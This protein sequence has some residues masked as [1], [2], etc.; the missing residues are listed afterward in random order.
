MN[1][2]WKDIDWLEAMFQISNTGRLRSIDRII[3]Y[4]DGRMYIYKSKEYFPSYNRG[5]CIQTLNL[6]GKAIPVKFHR[7]VAEAFIPN[8]NNLPEVNHIDGDKTNNNVSNLEWCTSSENKKHAYKLGLKLPT[9]GSKCGMSKLTENQVL[10]I[11][12]LKNKYIYKEIA[13]LFNVD[14]S[15]ISNIMTNKTWKHI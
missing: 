8:P 13:K 12:Q 11:R 10:E 1:E 6:N 14:N 5:Y 9:S 4:I 7:L 3:E 15:T 2:I